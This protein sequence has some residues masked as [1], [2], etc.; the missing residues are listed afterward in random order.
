MICTVCGAYS[1]EDSQ[2]CSHCATPFAQESAAVPIDVPVA[3]IDPNPIPVTSKKGRIW[4]PFIVLACMIAAG[5]T[6][7]F[8]TREPQA[9]ISSDSPWFS[10][11]GGV[12]FFDKTLYHGSSELEIPST[13]AG[14]KVTALGSGCFLNCDELTTVILPDTLQ[15]ISMGAFQNCDALR[16]I[17]IPESVESI[18]TAAFANCRSLEAICIPYTVKEIG[19]QAFSGCLKLSFI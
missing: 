12:L 17:F 5:L 13:I 16:G 14:Q 8:F 10:I 9:V 2:V 11:K 19:N 18:G 4:V 3:E 6:M 15:T 7:F 1:P